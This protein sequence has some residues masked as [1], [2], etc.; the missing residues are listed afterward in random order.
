MK[1]NFRYVFN[2]D[3]FTYFKESGIVKSVQANYRGTDSDSGLSHDV[4]I[5]AV[6]PDSNKVRF[7][8]VTKTKAIKWLDAELA[9]TEGLQQEYKRTITT[10]ITDRAAKAAEPDPEKEVTGRPHGL[11]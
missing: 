5:L 11:E 7:K 2:E 6:L 4:T 8:N 3:S 1:I 9:K 10:A